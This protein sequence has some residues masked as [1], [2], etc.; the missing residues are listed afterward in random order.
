[1][2][3]SSPVTPSSDTHNIQ[4][5]THL[6]DHCMLKHRYRFKRRLQ[7]LT[8]QKGQP[9]D[10]KTQEA[11]HALSLQIIDSVSVAKKRY[12]S[13]TVITFNDALP[14][15]QRRE[16]IEKAITDNQVIILAGETGSGKT[17]QIPKMCMALGRGVFGKIGHTQPRRIA[18]RTVADRIASELNVELGEEVGYQVRFND[19]GNET[20]KIKVMT[21][22]ILLADIQ[23]DPY[24]NQY[25]TLIID[26]A[27]ERSLNID[28]LLGYL[29]QLLPKRPDLK[30]IVTSAT[31]D[32]EKFSAFFNG[33]PIIEVSGRT[34][35]VEVLYRPWQDTFDELPL[36]IVDAVT[37]IQAIS[38]GKRGDILIFLSGER[39]IREVSH[40]IKKANLHQW[41]V[42][43]LYARLSL[44]E[45]NKV[46]AQSAARKIVL[47]TNVA[48]TS[49]TVP[50][51]RYVIDPGTA[52]I[53]RYS[54]KSKVERLPIE[55][56]SQA[57]ANQRKG[58][59]GRVS[60]GVC[61]RLYE[62]D[63]FDARP[64]FTDAEILRSNLAAVILQM[65]QMGFGDVKRFDF[66]DKPDNRLISDGFKLLEELGAVNSKNAVTALGKQMQKLPLDPRFSR[67]LIAASEQ[68]CLKE[69]LIIVS[70]L[71]IQDPRERPADK[72]QAADLKH[73]RFFDENSD[74][75][76]FINLW[77]WIEQTRQDTSQNQLKK[78]C[79]KDFINYLRVRE[80]RE[81][82][83]QISSS[84]KQLGL[85]ENKEPAGYNAVHKALVAG[86]L[87]N[88]GF[89]NQEPGSRD[90]L[91]TR[92]RKFMIFPGS[93]LKKARPKWLVSAQMLETSQLFAHTVAKVETEWVLHYAKHLLK[94]H[95][96]EPHYDAKSG[97][98]K[99]FVRISLF[100]LVLVEKKRVGYSHINE[101]EARD[102]FIRSALVE[103]SYRGKGAFFNTNNALIKEVEELEAKSRR[104]D[105]LVDDNVIYHFYNDRIPS[106]I[107]NLAGFEFWR[108]EYEK[109]NKT[110]LYLSKSHLMLHGAGDVTQAQFPDALAFGDISLP[111]HYHFEPNHPHDGVS[112]KVPVTY[113][114]LL[115]SHF[116]EWLVPGLL[117]DKCI[118]LVKGL[119]KA[120]RKKLV[121]VPDYVDRALG[122][123][124]RDNTPLT[125]QLSTELKRLSLV[126]IT[127]QD[128]LDVVVDDYYKM[129]ILVVD[130]Q[131]KILD[132]DRDVEKL[133]ARYRDHVQESIAE[134]GSDFEQEGIT[135]WDFGDLPDTIDLTRGGVAVRGFPSLIDNITSVALKVCDNP[136]DAAVQ[137]RQGLARLAAL[138]LHSHVK[139]LKKDLLRKQDIGLAVI[140]I[141]NR[142]AVADDIVLSAIW[143]TCFE[144]CDAVNTQADFDKA[145]EHGRKSIVMF[146]RELEST[147]LESLKGVVAVK[148]YMKGNKSALALALTYGDINQQLSQ[149]FFRGFLFSVPPQWFDSYPRYIQ[150]MLARMEKAA[151][152]PQ[153]D[154]VATAELTDLYKQHQDRL[155]KTGH[156]AYLSNM[157]W[158][159]YR[160]MLEELR[161]SLFAQTLKTKMP[162]SV[163]R[164]S[165]KWQESLS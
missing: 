155:H 92:N 7:R 79:Q 38:K 129:N 135:Q 32:L 139:L 73:R 11:L 80:W 53:K 101:K 8:P 160:W 58:R 146:A 17:T 143:H 88:V 37:E 67:M 91:G 103:G 86:L 84:L 22:G 28:F 64:A 51:I 142:D 27:H 115:Q 19:T 35:P 134:A 137:T 87:S 62:Q 15:T 164:L 42:V 16:E 96:F 1:M 125:D 89:K 132:S 66:L 119:P 104:R 72:Q 25:D 107:V 90:Y 97:Q 151:Q 69:V 81:T 65:L 100:G 133:R 159:E 165:K 36:A 93:A 10:T 77:Q 127:P 71:S 83:F 95:Y 102:I 162:V 157:H 136:E 13:K 12:E 60:E 85:K 106:H 138:S 49:I 124:K 40:A 63:D 131:G 94:H 23:N 144:G 123:L 46:F 148:K 147:M 111:L 114:H 47:A 59:C 55:A 2:T 18:A 163:K 50:G 61:I 140:D 3:D 109:E 68:N 34:Y 54:V 117:R 156:Y 116:L 57:S 145:I 14:I 41:V 110:A 48:E 128:W 26:E 4:S 20:T 108:K 5:M 122:R 126:D 105:I 56:V 158:Q 99:A 44:A 130:S 33:A 82:H 161:V 43:P 141:G 74:F 24:L 45:Q 153:K 39:E 120:K 9:L 70:G 154:R 150:A 152:N 112:V 30:I 76:A 98:V 149:L 121:P 31:I 21:D 29:K 6:I 78:Q 113:L 52:R 118:A 75:T